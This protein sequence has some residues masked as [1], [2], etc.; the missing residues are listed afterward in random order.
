MKKTTL[1]SFFLCLFTFV[2]AQPKITNLS[3]P[4]SADL[5]GL[6]EISFSL[7]NYD[8]PY[9][10][11]VIDVYAEFVS[12]DDQHYRVNGFYYESYTFNKKNS[13]EVATRGQEKGWRVR[14]TPNCPGDWT[15]I[16]HAIDRQGETKMPQSSVSFRCNPIDTTKGFISVAN[17]RYLKRDA[18]VN[19]RMEACLSMFLR[20]RFSWF[21]ATKNTFR[22]CATNT[23][24]SA[25]SRHG[26]SRMACFR[27][28]W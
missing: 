28:L 11:D 18:M 26:C 5:F 13:Y 17:K 19:G 1:L 14:F 10:P 23:D 2:M 7:G 27:N 24:V 25:P 16:V 15:F 20:L 4:K 22:R 12:P 3:Y 8:N 6:Y 21:P 9:D